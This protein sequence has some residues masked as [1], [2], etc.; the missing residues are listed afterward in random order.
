LVLAWSSSHESNSSLGGNHNFAGNELPWDGVFRSMRRLCVGTLSLTVWG[1]AQSPEAGR[2]E[3]SGNHATLIVDS[4]RPLDSAAITLAEQFGMNISVEDPPYMFKDDVRDVTAEI[5]RRANPS[6]RLLVPKGGLL[7]VE[8]PVHANGYPEDT[9][10]LIERLVQQSNGQ[11][12][13]AYRVEADGG[14][15]TL[16]PTRTRDALGQSV[17][18]TPLLDRLVT[19]APGTRTV[20]ETAKL[21]AESLSAQTG[22]RV[23]CCQ[24][25]V[26]G[27]PW[28]M[29][30]ATFEARDEPARSVLKRL[31]TVSLQGHEN[32]YYWLERCDPLPSSW[33][34]INLRWATITGR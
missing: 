29:M 31:I 4:A 13:F 28:G 10:G 7:R 27:I 22:L 19:I 15:Y 12:P 20:A 24:A 16:V 2:I 32:H 23:S 6:K 21:M 25:V 30:N 34:F 26:A 3:R 1:F 18:I 14:L 33:C 9:R 17:R 8:F 11:F 5:A